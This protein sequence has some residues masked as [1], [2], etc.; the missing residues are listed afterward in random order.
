MISPLDDHDD[1]ASNYYARST[2]TK[3]ACFLKGIINGI[4]PPLDPPETS[5]ENEEYWKHDLS[6]DK[7]FIDALTLA[8]QVKLY[9]H[10]RFQM[11]LLLG[12]L[13]TTLGTLEYFK[14]Q[15]QHPLQSGLLRNNR[16]P[17]RNYSIPHSHST[18]RP[19]PVSNDSFVA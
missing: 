13:S 12:M 9:A 16:A 10:E 8:I 19:F 4:L 18:A 2:V 1:D 11:K 5:S 7:D 14:F 6:C 17:C 3:T 15:R